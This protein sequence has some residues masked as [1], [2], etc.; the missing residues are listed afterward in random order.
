MGVLT[1]TGNTLLGR[2]LAGAGFIFLLSAGEGKI[3]EPSCNGSQLSPHV[4]AQKICDAN[5][6]SRVA[7]LTQAAPSLGLSASSAQ[8][9]S[10]SLRICLYGSLCSRLRI[11][12]RSWWP[13]GRPIILLR[14]RA[15]RVG[16]CLVRIEAFSRNTAS[17]TALI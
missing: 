5:L 10:F 3:A 11:G 7:Q 15:E 9:P 14:G 1:V 6:I 4:V 16:T 17:E 2:G 8:P 12:R 13:R